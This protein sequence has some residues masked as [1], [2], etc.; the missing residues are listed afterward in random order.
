MICQRCKKDFDEKLQPIIFKRSQK[1]M[2]CPYCKTKYV[3][4]KRDMKV[5]K[6]LDTGQIVRN[7]PKTC[8]SKKERLRIR[9]HPK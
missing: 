3:E 2:R 4:T 1:F 7:V 6:T 9:R 8:M 5:Y